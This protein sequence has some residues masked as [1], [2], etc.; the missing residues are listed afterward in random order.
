MKAKVILNPYAG[1]WLALNKKADAESALKAAGVDYDLVMTER[2]GH[3]TELAA[4]AAT[5]GYDLIVSAGGDGSISEVAN[6]LLN[7]A[8]SS[9]RKPLPL[10]ILPLG[11]ANDLVVNLKLPKTLDE[12]ARTIAAGNIR[13]MDMGQ[14]SY[15]PRNGQR[16]FDNNSA[17][18][19]EP[20]VTLIQQ[21]IKRLRGVLRY[22]TATLMAVARNPSWHVEL[23]WENGHFAGPASLVTI[24]N[25]PLTG[26]LFYMTPHADP[27]DGLLTAVH[28]YLPTR[29][30]I[31][32]V[33]PSTMKS[34]AGSYVEKPEIH[35]FH[36]PWLRIRSRPET[37]LHADGEIQTE[38]AQEIEYRILPGVLPVLMQ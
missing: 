11:T 28:G 35:E 6:G 16:Y 31:L 10:G 1:R 19:L 22:L 8:S 15:A 12:S 21:S 23:E 17:I 4:Q 20:T 9:G 24:G 36:T 32:S 37:P 33:L 29:L 14:V 25:N 13:W 7:A 3:G 18:G 30:K 38:T 5:Q 2:P 26:G 34:E 27:F